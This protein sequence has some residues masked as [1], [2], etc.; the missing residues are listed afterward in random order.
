MASA[1]T[2]TSVLAFLAAATAP[3][4]RAAAATIV[5][6]MMIAGIAITAGVV[7]LLLDPYSPARLVTVVT[8]VGAVAVTV[9]TLTLLGLERTASIAPAETET[10]R[11]ATGWPRSGPSSTPARFTQF[12]FLAMIAF[13]LQDLI[14]EPYAGL[15]FGFTP[16][17][18]TALSGAQNG[19]V[20][21]RDADG[22]HRWQRGYAVGSLRAWVI[23]GCVGSALAALGIA[24]IGPDGR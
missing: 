24:A 5:W 7:G 4:R 1:I 20:L 18:S 15:V 16:G 22:G 6:L 17:Q 19:G 13:F 10:C 3:E 12:V 11:C 2:G 9:T 21:C 8:C 23:A 14:L